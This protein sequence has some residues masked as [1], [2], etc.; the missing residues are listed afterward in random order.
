MLWGQLFFVYRT[1]YNPCCLRA[2]LA[3]DCSSYG[4]ASGKFQL[5]LEEKSNL[6]KNYIYVY[7]YINF[8]FFI[9][10]SVEI[11]K[12]SPIG[13][14]VHC[15]GLYVLHGGIYLLDMVIADAIVQLRAPKSLH[16]VILSGKP[17][18]KMTSKSAWFL[19]IFESIERAHC[20]T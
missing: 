5:A 6:K 3:L 10:L 4:A 16:E 1:T 18:L 11:G 15:V 9:G 17:G 2:S 13:V 12:I 7:L 14:E 19:T 20:D 8:F